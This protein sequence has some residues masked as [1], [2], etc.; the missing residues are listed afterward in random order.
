MINVESFSSLFFKPKE[1][2]SPNVAYC[3]SRFCNLLARKPPGN[4][5]RIEKTNATGLECP[6]CRN[7]LEWRRRYASKKVKIK[8][9]VS[10]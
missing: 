5:C 10:I 9:S 2:T 4:V 1:S 6:D 3:N 7:I 8:R